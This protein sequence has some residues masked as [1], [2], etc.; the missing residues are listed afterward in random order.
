MNCFKNKFE[1]YL[2]QVRNIISIE[3]YKNYTLLNTSFNIGEIIYNLTKDVINNY[4]KI[5][6]KKIGMKY[7]EYYTKIKSDINLSMLH[8]L[9]QDDINNIFQTELLPFLTEQNNCTT[10]SEYNIALTTRQ[11]VNNLMMDLSNDIKNEM[12]LLK[13]DNYQANFQCLLDFTNSGI[14][15]IKPIC[16]SMKLFLSFENEEQITKINENIRNIIQN[17]LEDFLNTIIPNFGNEFFERII[18]YNINFKLSSLYE[19]LIN[20]IEQTLLY[21]EALEV[22]TA[23]SDL[24]S[25]LK[26]RLIKL[27]DLDITV[28]DKVYEIKKLTEE[29]L[30]IYIHYI[31]HLKFINKDYYLL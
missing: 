8:N 13:G 27:N 26:N 22:I 16:D 20:A 4:E 10:C 21:Y 12:S 29:K 11:S 9:I 6:K 3:E 25:D 1:S 7:N 14:N 28:M 23:E 18:D 31:K 5:I 19:N 24:P 2:I 15:V 17:N 30:N